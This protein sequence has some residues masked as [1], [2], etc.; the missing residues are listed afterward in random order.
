MDPN[1]LDR[2]QSEPARS[3]CQSETH[4][5]T[6]RAERRRLAKDHPLHILF[7]CTD[8]HAQANLLRWL[9]VCDTSP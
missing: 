7:R 4:R 3:S 1:T 8:C 6:K 2:S 5:R 9:T